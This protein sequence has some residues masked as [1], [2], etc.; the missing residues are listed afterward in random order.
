[1]IS[2]D[3]VVRYQNRWLQLERP[4]R[5][6]VPA[7]SR[8]LVRENEAGE[9]APSLSRAPSGIPRTEG[10]LD[11]A[12]IAETQILHSCTRSSVEKK[13]ISAHENTDHFSGLV[14][15]QPGDI[16]IVDKPGTLLMWYDRYG[17]SGCR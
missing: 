5:P 2:E 4:S 11:S 7:K 3:W 12:S 8:V 14:K 10:G 1:V 16:S 9:V 13:P 6:R 15:L 17:H